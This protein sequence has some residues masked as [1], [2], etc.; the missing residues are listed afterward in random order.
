MRKVVFTSALLSA[1][2]IVFVDR[3]DAIIFLPA[4]ILIPIAKIIAV[5][6]GGF[7]LPVIGASAFVNKI[8]GKSAAKGILYGIIIL[9]VLGVI[10]AVVLKLVNPDRPLI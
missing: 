8:T 5:L 9:V 10:A 4:I 3:V 1:F 7:S 2:F 6:I